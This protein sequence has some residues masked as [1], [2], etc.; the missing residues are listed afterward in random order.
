MRFWLSVMLLTLFYLS[1]GHLEADPHAVDAVLPAGDT[2]L[3]ADEAGHSGLAADDAGHPFLAADDAGTLSW[4]Q[5][6]LGTL[7]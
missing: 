6:M 5:M 3:A 1:V 4:L 7:S 2:V